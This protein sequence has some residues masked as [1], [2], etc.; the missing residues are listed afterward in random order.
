MVYGEWVGT[1]IISIFALVKAVVQKFIAFAMA[2]LLL[3]STTSWKVEK[4]FCMG[5]LI[6]VAFF[7]EADDCGMSVAR[8]TDGEEV[9][10][11]ENSC[12]SEEVVFIDGQDDLKASYDAID[13]KQ[14]T[15]FVAFAYSYL[16]FF[17]GPDVKIPP[18]KNY[19]PPILI[20]DIQLLDQVF[21]I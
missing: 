17:N 5:H 10:Q 11:D 4:H 3:A 2:V 14:Q 20:K 13:L 1:T 15:F 12:C 9:T 8:N 16:N 6:D 21:L 7:L 19:P 18:N